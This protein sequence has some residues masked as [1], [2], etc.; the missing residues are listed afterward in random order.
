MTI[1]RFK[2]SLLSAEPV[3]GL[4]VQV[5]AQPAP[6]EQLT[7]T[8]PAM[9]LG[10]ALR[11]LAGLSGL[12]LVVDEQLVAGRTAP[13]LSGRF[14]P[15]EAVQRLLAGSRLSSRT[16]DGTVVISGPPAGVADKRR[17]ALK[18]QN[19][20]DRSPPRLL[21]KPGFTRDIGYDPA[22]AGGRGQTIS[23]QIRRSW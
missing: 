9:A 17:L 6:Q 1:H 3:P 8:M 11:Q 15:E 20:F 22:N 10:A 7:P 19:L 16:A 12:N 18:I 13:A 23:F 14:N 4:T 2:T 5:E 21:P